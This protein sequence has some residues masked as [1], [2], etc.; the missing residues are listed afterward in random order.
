MNEKQ[1]ILLI[2]LI[3]GSLLVIPEAALPANDRPST[4]YNFVLSDITQHNAIVIT[5][6]DNFTA[7]GWQGNGTVDSPYLISDLEITTGSTCINISNT[8]AYFIIENCHLSSESETPSGYAISFKSVQNGVI[9]NIFMTMKAVGV[10]AFDISDTTFSYVTI[11]DTD[12]GIFLEESEDCH[13]V[14]STIIRNQESSAVVLYNSDHCD[15]INNQL[16]GNRIGFLSNASEWITFSNNTIVGN[17]EYGIQA[18]SGTKKLSVYWNY[19]GWNNQNAVDNGSTKFWDHDDLGNWW[20]DYGNE[21]TY[22]VPGTAKAKDRFPKVWNDTTSPDISTQLFPSESDGV[23]ITVEAT[24]NIA[25]NQVLLS[26]SLDDGSSW[27]NVT[28]DWSSSSWVANVESV[29][30]GTIIHYVVYASDYA[31]NWMVTSDETYSVP[32]E[33]D[34]STTESTT[35]TGTNTNPTSGADT[36][37]TDG[38]GF[39]VDPLV[40][41]GIVGVT[42]IISVVAILMYRHPSK[43]GRN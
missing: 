34:A 11:S 35:G 14:N 22:L 6:N 32:L 30:P 25:V 31:G 5:H 41:A 4:E 37:N 18:T 26:F 15:I 13:I 19:I 42:A 9:R 23:H 38:T 2:I 29:S 8:D 20:S 27:S 39:A 33:T 43:F 40:I 21:S 16:I 36:N 24:D 10:T 3:L 1:R 12:L 7:Q 28:M 17:S